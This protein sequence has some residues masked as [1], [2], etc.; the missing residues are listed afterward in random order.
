IGFARSNDGTIE[1]PGLPPGSY[2]LFVASALF[3]SGAS[4]IAFD[5]TNHDVDLGTIAAQ[6]LPPLTG[7][8]QPLSGQTF[9]GLRVTLTPI[10]GHDRLTVNTASTTA[11]I[12]ADGTFRFTNSLTAQATAELNGSVGDGIYQVAMSGLPS[13]M[14]IATVA[15]GG[16]DILDTGLHIE[17]SPHAPLEIAIG[18]GGNVQGVVKKGNDA[19]QDSLVALIPSSPHRGNLNLF[20]TA[21]TDQNGTFTFR[22][23]APGDYSILAWEEV[24]PNAWLN[25]EFLKPFESQAQRISVVGTSSTDVSVRVIPVT[26]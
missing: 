16:R 17:G 4:H 24:E 20:K 3:D 15:Y 26:N 14:Y 21:S 22:G 12:N 23:V 9:E 19:V 7:K 10:D 25:A 6:K 2:D 1:S 13:N 18:A 8:V 5:I 11:R